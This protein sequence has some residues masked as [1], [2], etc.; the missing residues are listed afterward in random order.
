MQAREYKVHAI[1]AE[2][3]Q[4][5]KMISLTENIK[6]TVDIKILQEE[7]KVVQAH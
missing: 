1:M 5:Q 2:L 6:T 7:E 4:R 3:K